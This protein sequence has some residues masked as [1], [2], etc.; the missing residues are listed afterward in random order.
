MYSP[1]TVAKNTPLYYF[2]N[3]SFSLAALTFH[4]PRTPGLA[5]CKKKKKQTNVGIL[6]NQIR[7][8]YLYTFSKESTFTKTLIYLNKKWQRFV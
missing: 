3:V 7:N 8:V 1:Q 4:R 6:Q 2:K 5:N